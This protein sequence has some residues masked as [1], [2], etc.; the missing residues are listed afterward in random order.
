RDEAYDAEG[1]QAHPVPSSSSSPPAERPDRHGRDRSVHHLAC[2]QRPE[3][4]PWYCTS[5]TAARRTSGTDTDR[6]SACLARKG[7]LPCD[8]ARRA[9]GG[10]TEDTG[11]LARAGRVLGRSRIRTELRAVAHERRRRPRPIPPVRPE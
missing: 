9:L 11:G 2:R 8:Q 10:G 1:Q 6:S 3:S 5:D 7:T 4:W